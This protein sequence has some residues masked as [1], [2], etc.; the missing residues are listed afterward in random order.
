MSNNK[1]YKHIDSWKNS[2]NAF[3]HQ[4]QINKEAIAN[5]EAERVPHWVNLINYIKTHNPKRIVDVGCG[6]GCYYPVL[7]NLDVEYIGYDY[8]QHAIDIAK[9][10]WGGNFVCK[11]YQEIMPEDIHSGDLIVANGLT[12]ILPEGD[13]CIEHL[14]SLDAN[15]LLI[16]RI[17]IT[18]QP[19]YFK[20]Y[21]AYGIMTYEFYHNREQ[22]M[23]TI[24]YYGYKLGEI[25]RLFTPAEDIFD[26][27]IRKSK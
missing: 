23:S 6:I 18:E 24:D 11:L 4:L 10:E 8:S 2:K 5:G 13:K 9:K 22:L 26:I 12:D 21:M 16:Q 20:E 19:N 3:L 14:L 25:T 17:R 7:E 15:E 27:E 1:Q